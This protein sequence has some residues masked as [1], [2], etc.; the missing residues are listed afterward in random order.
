LKKIRL[1]NVFIT[2]GAGYIGSHC[3]I[4]LINNGY[5]PI[6]LDNFSNSQKN[7][8]Q[9]LEKITQKKIIFYDIDIRDKTKLKKI[10][11]KHLWLFS[12]SLCRI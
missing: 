12:N 10:F 1:K 3:V 7:I 6:I 11:K 9:K 8:I 4:S 5:N 2:G